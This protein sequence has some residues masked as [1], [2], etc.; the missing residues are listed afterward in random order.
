[1]KRNIASV[2][3][4]LAVATGFLRFRTGRSFEES[5]KIKITEGAGTDEPEA[6]C[7]KST[8]LCCQ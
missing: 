1:M 4:A 2:A 5:L 6:I 8:E 7:C 3:I